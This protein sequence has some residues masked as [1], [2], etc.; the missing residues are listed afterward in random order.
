MG[1][2]EMVISSEM[3]PQQRAPDSIP[4]ASAQ[5]DDPSPLPGPDAA[6][7]HLPEGV[8]KIHPKAIIWMCFKLPSETK[9]KYFSFCMLC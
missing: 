8:V 3:I 9:S 4:S 1:N 7:S 2:S 6:A 5:R